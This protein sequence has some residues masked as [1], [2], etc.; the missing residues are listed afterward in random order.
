MKETDSFINKEN[1]EEESMLE[2][3]RTRSKDNEF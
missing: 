2:R 3:R 1:R